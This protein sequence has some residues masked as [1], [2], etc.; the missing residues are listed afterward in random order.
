MIQTLLF[1]L[2][3]GSGIKGLSTMKPVEKD[4]IRPLL[5]AERKNILHFLEENGYDYVEDETNQSNQYT[6]NKIRHE[7]I[8]LFEKINPKAVPHICGVAEKLQEVWGYMD[9][10]AEKLCRGE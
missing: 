9:R 6:R 4:I 8:P 1:H 3:R 10:E 5:W 7:M 2:S